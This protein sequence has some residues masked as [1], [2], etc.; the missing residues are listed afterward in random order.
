MA[1]LDFRLQ[2]CWVWVSHTESSFYAIEFHIQEG[3]GTLKREIKI[4][5]QF[6]TSTKMT[7]QLIFQP[8]FEYPPHSH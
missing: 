3:T 6:M 4:T 8:S 2:W 5:G 7:F 1:I